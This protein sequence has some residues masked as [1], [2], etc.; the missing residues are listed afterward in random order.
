MYVLEVKQT[1]RPLKRAWVQEGYVLVN[2]LFPFDGSAT[3]YSS[4]TYAS[5]QA[6]D[7]A[8]NFQSRIAASR[9]KIRNL[10]VPD[11]ELAGSVLPTK[12]AVNVMD[13]V[14]EPSYAS[15]F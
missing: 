8:N 6:T 5:S 7:N 3:G 12:M 10:S 4:V 2:L 1:L 9:C 14:P 15:A 11:N 13:S